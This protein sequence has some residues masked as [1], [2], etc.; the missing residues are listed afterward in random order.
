MAE[1]HI[2]DLPVYAGDVFSHTFTWLYE[3]EPQSLVGLSSLAQVRVKPDS[4]SV[5]ATMTVTKDDEAGGVFTI[6]MTKEQTRALPIGRFSCHYDVQFTNSGEPTTPVMGRF[7][8]KQD[9]SRS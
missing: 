1:P 6:S 4:D 3:G 7:S 9:V 2:E 5:L 8:V